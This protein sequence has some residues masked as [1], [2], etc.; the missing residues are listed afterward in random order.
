MTAAPTDLPASALSV[1]RAAAEHD[2]IARIARWLK[3]GA[4]PS[5]KV[6]MTVN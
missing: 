6:R 3:P 1:S 2:L 5:S 4:C